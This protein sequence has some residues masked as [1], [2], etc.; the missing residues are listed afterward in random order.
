[1]IIWNKEPIIRVEMSLRAEPHLILALQLFTKFIALSPNAICIKCY[2]FERTMNF[3]GQ[4]VS[5]CYV[6]FL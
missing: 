4:F 5:L 6:P 1:M 2:D 3:S